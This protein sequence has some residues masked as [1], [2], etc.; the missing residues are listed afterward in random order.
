LD[1]S[2]VIAVMPLGRGYFLPTVT[3]LVLFALGIVFLFLFLFLIWYFRSHFHSYALPSVAEMHPVVMSQLLYG[4]VAPQ[5]ELLFLA[6]EGKIAINRSTSGDILI[7]AFNS[8]PFD[9]PIGATMWPKLAGAEELPEFMLYR[10]LSD[11]GLVGEASAVLADSGYYTDGY[12][13]FFSLLFT[14]IV[15]PLFALLE[16]G[17]VYQGFAQPMVIGMLLGS[18]GLPLVVMLGLINGLSIVVALSFR[19]SI[20]VFIVVLSVFEMGIYW[21]RPLAWD[22]AEMAVFGAL[23]GAIWVWGCQKST[24]ITRKGAQAVIALLG[25]RRSILNN[26][27]AEDA[28]PLVVLRHTAYVAALARPPRIGY[29]DWTTWT[30]FPVAELEYMEDEDSVV[31]IH[32]EPLSSDGEWHP[33]TPSN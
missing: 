5:V 12:Q 13:V 31:A 15:P 3:Q 6:S 17:R 9:G 16:F 26:P 28:D 22:T 7:T 8:E 2:V 23:S 30:T 4:G 11:H 24:R 14:L 20:A 18:V 19:Y 1:G 21:D 25:Y 29:V 32:G 10:I 27:P 33:P